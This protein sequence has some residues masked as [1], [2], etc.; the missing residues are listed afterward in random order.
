LECRS[1]YDVRE[2]PIDPIFIVASNGSRVWTGYVWMKRTFSI[3]SKTMS[4]SIATSRPRRAR[5]A[6]EVYLVTFIV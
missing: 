4:R 5:S 2:P 6:V 3:T 1:H